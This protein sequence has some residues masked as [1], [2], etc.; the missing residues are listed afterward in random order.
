MPVQKLPTPTHVDLHRHF[1][2]SAV[3]KTQGRRLA[4]LPGGEKRSIPSRIGKAFVRQG[5]R[6]LNV[7]VPKGQRAEAK[8][9][10]ALRDCSHR[11]GDLIGALAAS[12][13]PAA[14][15]KLLTQQID[16]CLRTAQQ[17][18]ALNGTPDRDMWTVLLARADVHL[19]QLDSTQ[20]VAF[21][22]GLEQVINLVAPGELA[23]KLIP[24]R[25]AA[26]SELNRRV[27]SAACQLVDQFTHPN[28]RPDDATVGARLRDFVEAE[29]H[30]INA[31]GASTANKA[32]TTHIRTL[33][34]DQLQKLS[35]RL[36][37]QIKASPANG[38]RH[39]VL[40]QVKACAQAQGLQR[41]K[42]DFQAFTQGKLLPKLR[43]AIDAAKNPDC[44]LQ[45]VSLGFYPMRGKA[46]EFL[47]ARGLPY[48]NETAMPYTKA[49]LAQALASGD[50]AT[51][52]IALLL[53]RLPSA[54][55]HELAS[56]AVADVNVPPQAVA[57][58]DD[59]IEVSIATRLDASRQAF[60]TALTGLNNLM[61]RP[62]ADMAD[63]AWIVQ[64]SQA[65]DTTASTL[66]FLNKHIS[67]NH[68]QRPEVTQ[69]IDTA[70]ASLRTQLTAAIEQRGLPL[71]ALDNASL[72]ALQD[73]LRTLGLA[74]L[75]RE[76]TA[77]ID[78]RKA[79]ATE[80]YVAAAQP[81]MNA[82]LGGDF[83]AALQGLRALERAGNAAMTVLTA[84][85]A[86][87]D[88]E[89]VLAPLRVDLASAAVLSLSLEDQQ[90]LLN[91]LSSPELLALRAVLRSA[92]RVSTDDPR[93]KNNQ[94][95]QD[96][97]K[98]MMGVDV[99]LGALHIA[100]HE[101]VTKQPLPDKGSSESVT[102]LESTRE[103]LQ[104]AFGVREYNW[105]HG[106]VP[107]PLKPEAQ[108]LFATILKMPPDPG[109]ASGGLEE[110]PRQFTKDLSRSTY[111]IQQPDGS[112]RPLIDDPAN[113]SE[114][115]DHRIGV[116]RA[117]KETI[118]G[119]AASPAQLD[120][121]MNVAS[122]TSMAGFAATMQRPDSPAHLDG[123]AGL[124][125][126]HPLD[127][128]NTYVIRR[129]EQGNL[130]VRCDHDIGGSATLMLH[131]ASQ[132]VSLDPDLSGA[133]FT[134]ELIIT[135]DGE[136]DV[137]SD[138]AYCGQLHKAAQA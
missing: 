44:S 105:N 36:D 12:K 102:M 89:N 111:L 35:E 65:L 81:A 101:E 62:V 84:F 34:L 91:A 13:N 54:T 33:R 49:G 124:L 88:D 80:H 133:R 73:G 130:L 31:V 18:V 121:L 112:Y 78:A 136:V 23:M 71:N 99:I 107:E 96:L 17:V 41:A 10:E 21:R 32:M 74:S 5:A 114:G 61:A 79:A 125:L 4:V 83:H 24:L 75:T 2:D 40:S 98:A 77:A 76:T 135:P 63:D 72:Q 50:A 20:L 103:A 11:T 47:E 129:D 86:S 127:V 14:N 22:Q 90:K 100:T 137:Y 116:L 113:A 126:P 51:A 8:V 123:Q 134:V 93:F 26:T 131:E 85:G 37:T 27:D 117:A 87:L 109:E 108:A 3:G 45:D 94:A 57:A 92:G 7:L 28:Q 138:V 39:G 82:I 118:T 15:L 55:Q 53:E 30:C 68:V 110:M 95:M 48:T 52:D 120:K 128:K 122:Q 97:G 104:A 43:E 66:Q 106:L 42:D 6:A 64:L 16:A 132:M 58:L 119:L 19:R 46:K 115:A 1:G 60:D 9:R 38:V 69:A 56:T 70:L 59:L 25:K 67:A 29:Q